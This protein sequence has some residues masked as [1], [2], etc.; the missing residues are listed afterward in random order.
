[1]P[2][3]IDFD[4]KCFSLE[5]REK[6]REKLDVEHSFIIGTVGRCTSQKNQKFILKLL[7]DILKISPNAVYVIVGDGNQLSELKRMAHELMIDSHVRFV[8]SQDDIQAYL[9]SFDVF[10]FPSIFEGLGISLLEAQ[11]N[12]LPC[13]VSEQISDLAIISNSVAK[14]AL[15]NKE[16][17]IESICRNAK[18]SDVVLDSR[19]RFFDSKLQKKKI[20]GFFKL[21]SDL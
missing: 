17:W 19:A 10:V 16:S 18:R 8:G 7:P 5:K 11:V 15:N 9:S 1:M 21:G 20:E 3:L 13:V 2:N 4:T 14:V 12:G 6:T